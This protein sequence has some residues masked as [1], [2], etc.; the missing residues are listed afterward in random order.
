MSARNSDSDSLSD[1]NS[2]SDMSSGDEETVSEL[3]HYLTTGRIKDVKDPLAWWY[4]NQGSY[5]RLW[6]MACDYLTIPGK[7]FLHYKIIPTE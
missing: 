4:E 3:D 2:S 1:G 7:T 6:Q 5:P